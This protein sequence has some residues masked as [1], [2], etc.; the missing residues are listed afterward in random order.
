MLLQGTKNVDYKKT[1]AQACSMFGKCPSEQVF[2]AHRWSE[3]I[4]LLCPMLNYVTKRRGEAFKLSFSVRF[5][6]QKNPL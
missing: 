3:C 6:V 5:S 1:A 2:Q 4:V